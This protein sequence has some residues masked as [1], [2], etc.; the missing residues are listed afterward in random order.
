MSAIWVTKEKIQTLWGILHNIRIRMQ[1]NINYPGVRISGSGLKATMNIDLPLKPGSDQYNGYFKIIDI[2][3]EEEQKL[4]IV[5]G[6]SDDIE[7]ETSA[8]P[9]F[10]SGYKF[11]LDAEEFTVYENGS[12]Y[13]EAEYDYENEDIKT[14]VFKLY[15]EAQMEEL[16]DEGFCR[17]L[18]SRVKVEDEKITSFSQ[19]QTGEAKGEIYGDCTDTEEED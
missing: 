18:L 2:S 5:D 1:E 3:D 6:F 9:V 10:I 14:P 19:E 13:I 8:G 11:D 15:T 17:I 12:I 16:T 4:K 7:N